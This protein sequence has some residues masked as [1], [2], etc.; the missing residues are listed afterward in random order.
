VAVSFFVELGVFAPESRVFGCE[1]ACAVAVGGGAGEVFGCDAGDGG[2]VPGSSV[3]A[4]ADDAQ[5]EVVH[6][7]VDSSQCVDRSRGHISALR[8]PRPPTTGVV[9]M[10][11]RPLP[12]TEHF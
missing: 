5:E 12:P 3:L 1:L 10:L 7:G 4:D 2:G 6:L 9:V 11:D 8:E